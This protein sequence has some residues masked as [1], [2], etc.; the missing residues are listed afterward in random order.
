ML[1]HIAFLK[2]LPCPSFNT[3]LNISFFKKQFIIDEMDYMEIPH[4]NSIAINMLFN[5]LD[6]RSILYMWKA[7]LFD[8]HVILISSQTS[9]QFYVAE[10]LKQLLF[11]LTWQH[12]YVQPAG[13]DLSDLAESPSPLI[14][15]CSDLHMGFDHFERLEEQGFTNLAIL[16]IDGSYTNNKQFKVMPNEGNVM[17]TLN[18]F[19]NKML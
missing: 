9:L 18:N 4:R 19:K 16:D 8:C 5:V 12:S 14:F 2:T 7:L 15:C 6:V 3:K 13:P 1:A 17:R 10:A 11:P